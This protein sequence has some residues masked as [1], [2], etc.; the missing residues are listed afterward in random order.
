MKDHNGDPRSPINGEIE[1]LFFATHVDPKTGEPPKWSPFGCK[2]V[3]I[4]ATT[5]LT[6]ESNLY[7]ADFYCKCDS[8]PHYVTLVLTE[9][10][11]ETD[12]FCEQNLMSLDIEDNDFLWRE[13]EEVHVTSEVL[14]EVFYTEDIDLLD[15]DCAITTGPSTGTSNPKGLRKNRRCSQCNLPTATRRRRRRRRRDPDSDE[16]LDDRFAGLNV[17]RH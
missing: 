2:R 9:P 1:G 17:F 16:E 8:D 3:S 14:V 15:D 7:F 11:S 13:G 6:T 4:P 5:L 12:G 10:S